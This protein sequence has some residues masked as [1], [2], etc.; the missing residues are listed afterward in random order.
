MRKSCKTKKEKVPKLT[1][2]QYAAYINALKEEIPPMQRRD[3]VDKTSSQECI[4]KV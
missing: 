3:L 2:A 4:K 1:E